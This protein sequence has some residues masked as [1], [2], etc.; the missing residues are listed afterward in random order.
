MIF[1]AIAWFLLMVFSAGPVL[2]FQFQGEERRIFLEPVYLE[3][4]ENPWLAMKRAGCDPRYIKDHLSD[5]IAL[6]KIDIRRTRRLPVGQ[7]III[8]ASCKG[9]APQSVAAL[10][11]MLLQSEGREKYLQNE[12]ADF[13]I[14]FQVLA[15]EN[16]AL[17]QSLAKLPGESETAR[18]DSEGTEALLQR[19]KD[20]I[21]ELKANP[22]REFSLASLV[23]SSSVF[24]LF[25]GFAVWLFRIGKKPRADFGEE[26]ALVFQ[27]VEQTEHWGNLIDFPRR[28]EPSRGRIGYECPFCNVLVQS[29]GSR[30]HL[31]KAHQDTGRFEYYLNGKKLA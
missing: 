16:Q 31:R 18:K 17:R 1:T 21:A 4:G 13:Q 30:S 25:G 5:V 12:L 19:L 27:K 8:P 28:Y 11:K 2:A 26:E 7:K 9:E 3:K 29:G 23:L 20:E 6:S 22:N 15:A 14:R 10:S 24:L